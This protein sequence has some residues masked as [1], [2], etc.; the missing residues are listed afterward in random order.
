MNRT[1][2]MIFLAIFTISNL[3]FCQT[4]NLESLTFGPTDAQYAT[5]TERDIIFAVNNP[6]T[7]AT[8]IFAPQSCRSYT[9][10]PNVKNILDYNVDPITLNKLRNISLAISHNTSIYGVVQDEETQKPVMFA[11]VALYKDGLLITG[12]ETDIDGKYRFENI[13]PGTYDLE[14]S[15][16]GYQPTRIEGLEITSGKNNTDLDIKQGMGMDCE[17]LIINCYYP[18]LRADEFGSGRKFTSKEII[19]NSAPYISNEW[20]VKRCRNQKSKKKKKLQIPAKEET[21]DLTERGNPAPQERDP[22]EE[23]KAFEYKIFPNPTTQILNIEINEGV[24]KI[25]LISE[26]GQLLREYNDQEKGIIKLDL[27]A[28]NPGIYFLQIHM[29]GKIETEKVVV[30]SSN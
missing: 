20:S 24:D 10:M 18:L 5:Q 25:L 12:T 11:N 3:L 15:Y 23:E 30:I 8:F 22:R 27:T 13:Q 17:L 4:S 2:Y 19:P 6:S 26:L 16:I 1:F 28:Y 14:P 21:Q 9:S 7:P 29:G